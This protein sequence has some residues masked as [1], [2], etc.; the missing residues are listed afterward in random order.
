MWTA[1][2]ALRLM[3]MSVA[4]LA[5][6]APVYATHPGEH[7]PGREWRDGHEPQWHDNRYANDVYYVPSGA[8]YMVVDP[9]PANVA[10]EQGAAPPP[11]PA[12]TAAADQVFVYP[13]Q[14]QTAEQQAADRYACHQW[15]I[16]QAGV[17]PTTNSAGVPAQKRTDYQRAL[18][19]CLD[20]RGYT[21]R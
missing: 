3:L 5:V 10:V 18:G 11:P 9:P 19:A 15:A 13:R 12:Q 14:G 8:G 20:G 21:V 17:D 6:A 4:A 1:S 2:H 7:H 16:T